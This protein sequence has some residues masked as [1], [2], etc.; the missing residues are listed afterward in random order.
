[1]STRITIWIQ[2]TRHHYTSLLGPRVQ[3]PTVGA[4]GR[5]SS[6][7]TPPVPIKTP[8]GKLSPPSQARN[9]DQVREPRVHVAQNQV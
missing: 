9:G 1:V 7:A 5:G 2:G 6:R 3:T 8:D 4:P